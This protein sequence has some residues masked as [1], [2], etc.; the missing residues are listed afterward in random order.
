MYTM[1]M[2]APSFAF[3]LVMLGVIFN[4]CDSF[5]G[6]FLLSHHQR[7]TDCQ[8]NTAHFDS[9]L[10]SSSSP[11]QLSLGV[12]FVGCGTIASAIA[13]GLATQTK[14]TIDRIAVS[15]RTESKS[16]RLME[17]FSP[18]LLVTVHDNNQDILDLVD[19]IFV[20]VLPQQTSQVLQDLT[21]DASRHTLVSLVVR[22]FVP[23]PTNTRMSECLQHHMHAK[24][25]TF[26][27]SN[28]L[29]AVY[30]SALLYSTSRQLRLTIW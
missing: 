13:T 1:L 20:C 3:R 15:R 21:F 8:G 30:C 16:Q 25:L 12:G 2:L 10:S 17:T 22:F 24:K 18:D 11:T 7:A 5:L 19:L 6:A 28:S 26:S 14:V 27:I 29:F 23:P 9:S 4:G